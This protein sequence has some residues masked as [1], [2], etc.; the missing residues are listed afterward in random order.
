MTRSLE[1]C[2]FSTF[3]SILADSKVRT[4]LQQPDFPLV[5]R[6]AVEESVAAGSLKI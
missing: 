5:A 2:L 6:E 4:I 1:D 3:V